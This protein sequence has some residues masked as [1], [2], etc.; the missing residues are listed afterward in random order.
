MEQQEAKT[1]QVFGK[2][3]YIPR[4]IHDQYVVVTDLLRGKD[5]TQLDRENSLKVLANI[6]LPEGKEWTT[7]I[8]LEQVEA[9]HKIPMDV[10]V[11]ALKDFF[12]GYV[13]IVNAQIGILE[14]LEM[15][16]ELSKMN[17]PKLLEQLQA[18]KNA[19]P[20]LIDP[21]PSTHSP[22]AN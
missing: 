10:E 14:L 1:Y 7:E 11:E 16:N 2:T 5:T 20:S 12:V 4:I 9:F 15:Q 17:L 19:N 21:K 6:L 3:Y 13:N 8:G 22:A 18:L